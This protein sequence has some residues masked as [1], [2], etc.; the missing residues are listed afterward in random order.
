[1]ISLTVAL[2][3]HDFFESTLIIMIC[4]IYTECPNIETQDRTKMKKFMVPASDE[5]Q[6]CQQAS[7]V[8]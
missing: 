8:E 7:I 5:K 6:A 4:P 3:G 2:V 1:M